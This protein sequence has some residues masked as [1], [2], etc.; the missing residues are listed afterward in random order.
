M[1]GVDR[2]STARP[3]GEPRRAAQGGWASIPENLKPQEIDLSKQP[4]SDFFESGDGVKT[5][6]N[7]AVSRI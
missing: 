4:Q 2:A 6:E 7:A 3:D 5:P 1:T